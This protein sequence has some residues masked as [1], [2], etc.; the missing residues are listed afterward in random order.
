MDILTAFDSKEFKRSN[1]VGELKWYTPLGCGV[2]VSKQDEFLTLYNEK[3]RELLTSFGIEPLCA[4]FPSAEY[5]E[6][7]GPAKTYRLSDELIK[8]IQHLIDSVYFS[9]VVLPS[10]TIPTIE[11]GG[12]RSPKKEIPTFDFLRKLSVYFSYITAWNYLGIESRQNEKILIDGFNGKRT[13][14]WDDL[15]RVTK[16]IIYPHGDECNPF[17]STADMIA[18]LT[19]KKLWDNYLHLTPE[20]IAEV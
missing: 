1:K 2:T 15:E 4:C 5:F 11:V 10:A 17:I 8:S 6:K 7:A 13:S 16:P 3:L 19:D 20:N 9:F 12:Y 18:S 14:A